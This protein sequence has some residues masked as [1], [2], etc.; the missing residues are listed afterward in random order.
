M[1]RI[2]EEPQRQTR[3]GRWPMTTLEEASKLLREWMRC[4]A[5]PGNPVDTFLQQ[6]RIRDLLFPAREAM[7]F[8]F[9]WDDAHLKQ[10]PKCVEKASPLAALEGPDPLAAL[11]GALTEPDWPGV[12]LKPLPPDGT[13]YQ[14]ED[15]VEWHTFVSRYITDYLLE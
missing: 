10:Q 7:E 4:E 11:E 13:S 9:A 3:R 8:A 1:P 2:T 15:T 12:E 14:L 6:P 5:D